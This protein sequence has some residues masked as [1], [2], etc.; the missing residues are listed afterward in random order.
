MVLQPMKS[1]LSAPPQTADESQAL[2]EY[3]DALSRFD[4]RDLNAGWRSARDHHQRAFWIPVG[5]LVKHCADA[6]KEREAQ[7]PRQT[8]H[9]RVLNGKIE[10]WGGACQCGRCTSK[11]RSDGFYRAP[12]ESHEASARVAAELAYDLEQR[13]ASTAHIPTAQLLRTMKNPPRREPMD[14][15]PRV[16]AK[17][18]PEIVAKQRELAERYSDNVSRETHETPH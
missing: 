7:S 14:V 17:S 1:V 16:H 18:D 12:Q 10:P 9:G 3:A 8:I 5:T 13:L 2:E 6:R 15:A 4:P 11:T